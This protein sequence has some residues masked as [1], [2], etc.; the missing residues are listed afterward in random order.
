[1]MIWNVFGFIFSLNGRY[2]HMLGQHD[3]IQ[4]KSSQQRNEKEK[5]K[6]KGNFP[7][8]PLIS[9]LEKKTIPIIIHEM[10][11]GKGAGVINTRLLGRTF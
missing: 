4:R 2:I 9:T 3:I 10:K 5:M 6:R 11:G 7:A 1:M 8:H